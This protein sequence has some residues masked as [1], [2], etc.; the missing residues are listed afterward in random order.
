MLKK[1]SDRSFDLTLDFRRQG[2]K[3]EGAGAGNRL[4][5]ALVLQDEAVITQKPG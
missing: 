3:A 5:R 1:G 2:P 4:D